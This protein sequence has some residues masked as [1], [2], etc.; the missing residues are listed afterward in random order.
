MS[1]YQTRAETLIQALPYIQRFAGKTVVV[2]YGGSAMTD[3]GLSEQVAKDVVLMQAVG[4]RP[5]LLHGGGP[6]I[7]RLMQKVGL[8]PKKIG[9]MRVTDAETME[10]VEMALGSLNKKLVAGVHAA[11]GKAVGL[12]GK[13]GALFTAQKIKPEGKDLGFVGEV[14]DVKTEVLGT[15]ADGGYIPI[16]SSVAQG[17]DGNTYNVNADL[18]AGALAA[19]LRAEKLVVM[20][21]VEGLLERYPDPKSLVSK[22]DARKAQSLIADGKV[23]KGMIPKV[24]ACLM[25]LE[26]GTRSAHIID[27]RKPHSLLI[28]LFTD[29][30]I[31]TMLVFGAKG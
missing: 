31:G 22:L 28:E 30:G 6:E 9:G 4:I 7:D 18:A 14:S 16:V 26:G 24:Q 17:K 1:E 12:S 2:K 27:G 11:G 5:V 21:D 23:D 3:P 10:L 29:A 13:D 15:L 19:A 8:E 25:A 20:T